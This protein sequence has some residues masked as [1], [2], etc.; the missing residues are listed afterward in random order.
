MVRKQDWSARLGGQ[1]LS[2]WH[3]PIVNLGQHIWAMFVQCPVCPEGVKAE[4]R[5]PSTHG[6]NDRKKENPKKCLAASL[7]PLKSSGA[8]RTNQQHWQGR[9]C[10]YLVNESALCD[11]YHLCPPEF[12]AWPGL[13]IPGKTRKNCAVKW[14]DYKVPSISEEEPKTVL[15]DSISLPILSRL[16]RGIPLW[17]CGWIS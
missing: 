3:A 6:Q 13:P 4:S 14:D 2:L 7:C 17:I 16:R 11:C 9:L 5:T 12:P 8:Q 1:A 15:L 10:K